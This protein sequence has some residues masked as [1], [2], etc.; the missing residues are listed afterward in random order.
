MTPDEQTEQ[1]GDQPPAGANEAQGEASTPSRLKSTI[2]FPYSALNDA[3]VIADAL[4]KTWGGQ[5]SPDQLAGG[6]KASPRSGAFRTK[7]ATARTFGVVAIGRERIALTTLGRQLV[8]PKTIAAGRIE[9]FMAVPLF[10]AL[11]EAYKGVALPPD[12]GLERKIQDLGVSPK[13]TAKARQAFKKSAEI[14]GFFRHGNDRLVLPANLPGSSELEQSKSGGNGNGSGNG[15]DM[16]KNSALP[17]ALLDLWVTLLDEGDG[18][19]P[20]KIQEYLEAAR[21]LRTILSGS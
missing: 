15:G 14:A 5:A 11:A 8:D 19:S 17:N 20:D 2:S 1:Q 18:W 7:V 6:L 3:E 10:S 4:H 9:A 16:P 12:G 13:Q 21:K